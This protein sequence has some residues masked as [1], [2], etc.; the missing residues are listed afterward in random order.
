[1]REMVYLVGVFLV[2]MG[3]R[4]SGE[5]ARAIN[6]ES[7]RLRPRERKSAEARSLDWSYH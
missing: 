6:P 3:A 5:G 2:L 4:A 7:P 1:M